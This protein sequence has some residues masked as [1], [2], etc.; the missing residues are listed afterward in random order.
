MECIKTFL[1]NASL[2]QVPVYFISPVADSSLA[3]SNVYA[4]W[5]LQFILYFTVLLVIYLFL[6]LCDSK[7][8]KVYLPEQPFPHAEVSYLRVTIS[9]TFFCDFDLKRVL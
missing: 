2:S 3:H 7:Q 1:D 8:S 6:R 5:L 9:G 4:E